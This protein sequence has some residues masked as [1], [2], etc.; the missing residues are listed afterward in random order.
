MF[1]VNVLHCESK[2]QDTLL[3]SITSQNINPFSK[4][5]ER[6]ILISY[7]TRVIDFYKWSNFLVHQVLLKCRTI[8]PS[9]D[10]WLDRM[11][12][13][14]V[15]RGEAMCGDI[16]WARVRRKIHSNSATTRPQGRRARGRHDVQTT[17]S[18]TC[19]ALRRVSVRQRDVP[20]HRNVRYFTILYDSFF[21][22]VLSWSIASMLSQ[23]RFAI[24]EISSRFRSECLL[25][26]ADC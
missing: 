14:K 9:T 13:R 5:F 10:G 6:N 22:C 21:V 19:A 7:N 18:T 4:F 15:R 3:V 2:K 11:V 20:C 8:I 17:S 26:F 16:D 1:I 24:S 23:D 25:V 12:Q